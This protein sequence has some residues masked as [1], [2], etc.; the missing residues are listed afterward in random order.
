M[1]TF[2]EEA[3]VNVDNEILDFVNSKDFETFSKIMNQFYLQKL[4]AFHGKTSNDQSSLI[5]T[6]SFLTA[7]LNLPSFLKFEAERILEERRQVQENRE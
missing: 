7:Y 5:E 4:I 1:K 3:L 2:L 6:K